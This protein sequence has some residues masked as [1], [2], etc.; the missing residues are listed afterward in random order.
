V[1][2]GFAELKKAW[3]APLPPE[4]PVKDHDTVLADISRIELAAAPLLNA[5][6]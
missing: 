1:R 6:G 2:S 4:K 5:G 3:P